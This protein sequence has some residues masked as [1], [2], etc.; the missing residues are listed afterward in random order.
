MDFIGGI[1]GST[2]FDVI[3]ENGEWPD[4]REHYK[5]IQDRILRS[6]AEV[7]LVLAQFKAPVGG[8][9][10]KWENFSCRWPVGSEF[11]VIDQP[12][13]HHDFYMTPTEFFQDAVAHRANRFAAEDDSEYATSGKKILQIVDANYPKLCNGDGQFYLTNVD[14]GGHN[15][16]FDWNGNLQAIID[17]DA[18]R[19]LPVEVA[20]QLPAQFGLHHH[21][22]VDRW[23]WAYCEEKGLSYAAEYAKL[24][25]QAGQD[26]GIASF[27]EFFASHVES[28]AA[29][30]VAGL[31]VLDDEQDWLNQSWLESDIV[32]RFPCGELSVPALSPT[33][34]RSSPSLSENLSNC[35]SQPSASAHLD[36]FKDQ[37]TRS[38]PTDNFLSTLELSPRLRPARSVSLQLDDHNSIQTIDVPPTFGLATPL[39]SFPPSNLKIELPCER[40]H[41]PKQGKSYG[42]QSST[43]NP[44]VYVHPRIYDSGIDAL[45]LQLLASSSKL[46]TRKVS[47]AAFPNLKLRKHGTQNQSRVASLEKI[48]Q[49]I[50]VFP[51]HQNLIA[52]YSH[53]VW[54]RQL[55]LPNL[56]RVAA[57]WK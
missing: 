56:N 35:Y 17:I 47:D 46:S 49:S 48:S 2:F 33:S 28:E 14:F 44:L 39:P 16:I 19:F 9:L 5:P 43:S 34:G 45:D 55:Q 38:L 24:I 12:D 6:M 10:G 51:N 36:F 7:Q 52:T 32:S 1:S 40:P 25:R 50:R 11:G 4:R 42:E 20:A 37:A 8:T 23:T 26:C 53:K 31:F 18:L 21:Y 54:A 30:L 3:S 57:R 27:G 41:K 15:A 29:A 13:G 22:T